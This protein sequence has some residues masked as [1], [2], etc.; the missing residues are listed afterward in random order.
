MEAEFP[1]KIDAANGVRDLIATIGKDWLYRSR[2][3][4]LKIAGS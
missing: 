3:F 4:A 1:D 2:S